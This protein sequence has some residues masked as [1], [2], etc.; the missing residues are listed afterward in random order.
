MSLVVF[1][2][3]VSPARHTFGCPRRLTTFRWRSRVLRDGLTLAECREAPYELRFSVRVS[4]GVKQFDPDRI[5]SR[6]RRPN[7]C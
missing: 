4:S 7:G 2:K 5:G 6:P 1:P 3:V